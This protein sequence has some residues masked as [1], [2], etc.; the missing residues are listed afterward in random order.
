[1]RKQLLIHLASLVMAVNVMPVFAE[2]VGGGFSLSTNVGV[3]S[4]YV[5]RGISQSNNQTALQ[6]GIDLKHTSGAYAGFWM[7]SL[8]G[9][10][11][12]SNG[13][14]YASNEQDLYVGY[15]LPITKEVA[16]DVRYTEFM[17]GGNHG[18]N[19][20]EVHASVT[21]FGATLGT[22]Y[23][24]NRENGNS[25]TLHYYGS[26]AYTLPMNVGLSA[27]LGEYDLKDASF[28]S[29]DEKYAYWNVGVSK[30]FGGITWGLSYNNT[31]LSS[32]ECVGRT[33]FTVSSFKNAKQACGEQFVFSATK[34]M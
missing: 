11:R 9:W 3:V 25:S 18:A 28:T 21:A 6:G 12:T 4:D 33:M 17:Y 24:D 30:L 16:L 8:N 2:D 20:N 32:F 34:T 22:D 10:Y 31:D 13:N 1:M 15:N 23:A 26:Y 19:F 27:T 5:W 29:T 7:S 14:D